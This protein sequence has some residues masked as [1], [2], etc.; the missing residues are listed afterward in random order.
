[1]DMTDVLEPRKFNVITE[2]IHIY[3]FFLSLND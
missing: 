2:T 1:M 3:D